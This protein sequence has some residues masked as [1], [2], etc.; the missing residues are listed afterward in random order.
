MEM[1]SE[2]THKFDPIYYQVLVYLAYPT[3]SVKGESFDSPLT[4]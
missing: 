4:S 3:K 1:A 2:K